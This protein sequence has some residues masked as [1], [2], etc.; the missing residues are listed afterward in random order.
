VTQSKGI[1]DIGT[2]TVI[3][4]DATYS[5]VMTAAH[6]LRA[7]G[8]ITVEIFGTSM[9]RQSGSLGPSVGS[10]Q[11]TAVD[12]DDVADVGLLRFS[13]GRTIHA[14]PLPPADYQASRADQFCSF[15]CSRGDDPTGRSERLLKGERMD[16]PNGTYRGYECELEP[17][18]GRSGGGLFNQAGELIGVCDFAE[19]TVHHGLYAHTSSLRSILRKNGLVE[20]SEGNLKLPSAPSAPPIVATPASPPPVAQPP[21]AKVEEPVAPKPEVLGEIDR[22]IEGK[23]DGAMSKVIP[24]LLHLLS[25]SSG[26]MVMGLLVLANK[27]AKRLKLPEINGVASDQPRPSSSS[28]PSGLTSAQLARFLIRAKVKEEQAKRASALKDEERKQ[29]A[30]IEAKLQALLAEE[31]AVPKE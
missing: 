13:P 25:F 28:E 24:F 20:L 5:L 2:G 10:Y 16:L 11:G 29:E 8:T 4:S 15:G 21:K 6:V 31:T 14:S 18:Q 12:R 22:E 3:A 17:A 7:S 1:Q 27:L 23:V 9:D 26:G 30:S 19:P